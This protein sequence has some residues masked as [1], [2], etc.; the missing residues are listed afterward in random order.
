MTERITEDLV[1]SH[2]KSDPIFDQVSREEQKSLKDH[3]QKLFAAASKTGSGKP[4]YP[5]FIISFSTKKNVIIIVECKLSTKAHKSLN[6]DKPSAF[7]IDGLLHY[8]RA[9]NAVDNGY[10]IVG[11]AVSGA[12]LD[13]LEVSHFHSP[14]GASTFNEMADDKLLSIYS[15]LKIHQNAEFAKELGDIHIQQ[16]AQEYNNTLH[17]YEIPEH[18]RCTFISAVLVALQDDFFRNTYK[19]SGDVTALID[20]L[21]EA[22]KR[23][24]KLNGI[25]EGRRETILRQYESIKGHKIT[26]VSLIRNKLTGIEQ[27]NDAVLLFIE[28]NTRADLSLGSI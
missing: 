1:R 8:M 3:I 16:K 9:A 14:A 13:E 17:Y 11:I 12:K 25:K 5:E 22:C 10:D 7:A 15:Y 27:D 4:G 20:Q 23:V 26:S 28:K 21:I 18:E 2:F 24:L 19:Q 6:R